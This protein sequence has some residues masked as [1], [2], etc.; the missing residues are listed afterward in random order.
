M[1]SKYKRIVAKDLRLRPKEIAEE[2]K[3]Y[4]LQFI[5][6]KNITEELTSML[7]ED[8]YNFTLHC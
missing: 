8:S 3:S 6:E 1:E 4:I 2:L 5:P 7:E